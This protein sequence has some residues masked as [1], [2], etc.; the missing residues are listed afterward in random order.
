[1]DT[2]LNQ[3]NFDFFGSGFNIDDP[4]KCTDQYSLIYDSFLANYISDAS[5]DIHNNVTNHNIFQI[6]NKIREEQEVLKNLF[7]L[8]GELNGQIIKMYESNN[9]LFDKA[10]S[11]ILEKISKSEEN[12]NFNKQ[13]PVESFICI[14]HNIDNDIHENSDSDSDSDSENNNKNNK[15]VRKITRK[16]LRYRKQFDVSA[17]LCCPMTVAANAI[18]ISKSE[19]SRRWTADNGKRTWPYKK[20]RSIDQKIKI[21]MVDYEKRS[22]NEKKEIDA[23]IKKLNDEKNE[24]YKVSTVYI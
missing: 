15:P 20:I 24:C 13:M 18:G 6:L 9:S 1:M 11:G 12:N 17:Y 23:E 2:D 5:F 14:D 10:I 16:T 22:Q 3:Q 7:K 8:V 21:L 19:F 4:N